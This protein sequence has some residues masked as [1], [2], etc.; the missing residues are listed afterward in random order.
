MVRTT[1][2]G[3]DCGGPAQR[4]TSISHTSTVTPATN[5]DILPLLDKVC[6]NEGATTTP[7]KTSIGRRT[8]KRLRV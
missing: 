7:S 1:I 2:R 8:Q 4:S 6:E 3:R 5:M